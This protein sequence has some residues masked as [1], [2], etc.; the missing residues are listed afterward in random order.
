MRERDT[1][2]ERESVDNE[3]LASYTGHPD[4]GIIRVGC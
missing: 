4:C 2:R 1:Q 3:H